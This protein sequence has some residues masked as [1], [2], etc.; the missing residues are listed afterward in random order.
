MN[1]TRGS[2]TTRKL[3]ISST[4]I[5]SLPASF[6]AIFTVKKET[7]NDI[8]DRKAVIQ[9]EFAYPADFTLVS[10]YYEADLV[11]DKTD[12]LIIEGTYYWNVRFLT[13]DGSFI[14]DSTQSTFI[15]TTLPTQRQS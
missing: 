11:L 5:L 9:K 13:S 15:V 2:T 4:D 12:T 14:K 1:I 6:T 8:N 10:G 7:D 3:K